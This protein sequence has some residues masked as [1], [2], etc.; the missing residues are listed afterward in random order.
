MSSYRIGMGTPDEFD[1]PSAIYA[2]AAKPGQLYVYIDEK[3]VQR[4]S[5]LGKRKSGL[6]NR[7]L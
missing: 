4:I 5:Q 3:L 1:E 7:L 2:D 6:K